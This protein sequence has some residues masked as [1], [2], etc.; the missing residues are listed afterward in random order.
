MPIDAR[1]HLQPDVP[2]LVVL[3]LR[4]VLDAGTLPALERDG[5]TAPRGFDGDLV[6]SARRGGGLPPAGA[7]T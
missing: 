6:R 5:T 2:D 1:H 4:T 3:A 7:E